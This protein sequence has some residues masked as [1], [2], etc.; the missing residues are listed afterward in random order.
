MGR[1]S[2]RMVG[3]EEYVARVRRHRPSALLPLIAGA[4]AKYHLDTWWKS[5]YRKYTPWS[6]ADAARVSLAY[7]N[8]HRQG[9]TE[10]DLLRILDMYGQLDDHFVRGTADL[11][12][13][14]GFLLRTAG[15]QFLYQE[16]PYPELARSAAMLVQTTA[17][18]PARCLR[19]GWEEDLLGTSLSHYVRIAQLLWTSAVHSGG[20]F[21][22]ACL[23]TAG[24]APV[25]DIIPAETITSV[26]ETHF[27]TDSAAFR[28]ENTAAR[29]TADPLR[30]RFEYNPLR[31]R[32]FLRGYGPGYL[33]PVNH[34]IPAK[35]S[36]LGIYYTG[37]ARYG[38]A[39]AQD[40]G[41]LF[42]A[43]VGRQL[44]LLPDATV[45]PEIAYGRNRAR[46]V[47][48]IVITNELVLLVEVKSVRPTQHLRLATD[49]RL[50]ELARMLGHAYEQIDNTAALIR[51]GHEEFADIPAD[52]PAQGLIV[53]MEPFH[54]ANASLPDS[55]R[56]ATGVPVTVCSAGDLEYAVTITDAPLG[57][58]L[59]E[60]AADPQRSTY[61]LREA[62]RDHAHTPNPILEAGWDSYPWKGTAPSP[63]Q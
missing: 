53:T 45:I 55:W 62:L 2:G 26:T 46:S 9:A 52:R 5:P 63:V 10:A 25:C 42:E 12:S 49:R 19:P 6:L 32:P 58:L 22:P 27:V 33:A 13:L 54:L 36:P 20:R 3:D 43:Y 35:A 56:P 40:L 37:V 14:E 47:D 24:M 41:D 8:E 11:A 61:A 57:R 38:S 34:L 39:F 30:R 4:S 17:T 48:W 31:G 28:K 21:D 7:G 60:R 18:R 50:E 1:M 59:L 51:N 23:A 16:P 29:L 15:E 44:A